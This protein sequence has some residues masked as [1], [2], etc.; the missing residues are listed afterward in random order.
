MDEVLDKTITVNSELDIFFI[1]LGKLIK[2][3]IILD[4]ADIARRHYHIAALRI[5]GQYAILCDFIEAMAIS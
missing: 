2:E 4:F 5:L 3:N 1:A